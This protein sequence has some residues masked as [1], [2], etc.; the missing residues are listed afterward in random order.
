LILRRL[1]IGELQRESEAGD[2]RGDIER[3]LHILASRRLEQAVKNNAQNLT[4]ER[5][6]E[7][8]SLNVSPD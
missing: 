8:S 5:Q 1:K 2:I 3:L 6:A 4:V 7:P